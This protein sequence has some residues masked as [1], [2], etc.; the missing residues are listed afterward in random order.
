MVNGFGLKFFIK[1]MLAIICKRINLAK[2]PLV[3]YINFY[4]LYQCLVQLRTISEKRLMIDII[5]LRQ[6]YEER[7]IDEI[8][9]ICGKDNT[10]DAMTKTLSNSALERIIITNKAIIRL[11]EWVKQ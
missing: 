10:A 5:V 2:I 1:Q 8:R 7:E 11:E 3:L 6:S 4:L 9:L